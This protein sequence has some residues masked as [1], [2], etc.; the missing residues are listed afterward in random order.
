MLLSGFLLADQPSSIWQSKSPVGPRNCNFDFGKH[1]SK[2]HSTP[3]FSMQGVLFKQIIS[4]V[5]KS[6][7]SIP[8][9]NNANK[10][11]KQCIRILHSK[12]ETDDKY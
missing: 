12:H 7:N 2:F 6:L 8:F 9:C 5:L 1:A 4:I 10:Y 3:Q 11:E